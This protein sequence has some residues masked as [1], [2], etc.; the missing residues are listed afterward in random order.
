MDNDEKLMIAE[1]SSTFIADEIYGKKTTSFTS[2]SKF[3]M[4]A[5]LFY[6]CGMMMTTGSMSEV[7]LLLF[8]TQALIPL[9]RKTKRDNSGMGQSKEATKKQSKSEDYKTRVEKMRN[10]S[11]NEANIA[12]TAAG[13]VDRYCTQYL[14]KQAYFYLTLVEIL[15]VNQE[16]AKVIFNDVVEKAR[17]KVDPLDTAMNATVKTLK[18]M[19]VDDKKLKK[20]T[21]QDFR[22]VLDLYF[23][24]SF[25][26][27]Y[28][29]NE[30][31][32]STDMKGIF[33]LVDVDPN[34]VDNTK[35]KIAKIA[36]LKG[37]LEHMWSQREEAKNKEEEKEPEWK[38]TPTQEELRQKQKENAKEKKLTAKK[39][40][41][42]ERAE[43]VRAAAKAAK[44]SGPGRRAA[45]KVAP[46]SAAQ[47]EE[48]RVYQEQLI[49]AVTTVQNVRTWAA[50]VQHVQPQ[51]D[52][53]DTAESTHIVQNVQPQAEYTDTARR[54][55]E[56]IKLKQAAGNWAVSR[57]QKEH[58]DARDILSMQEQNNPDLLP[59]LMP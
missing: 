4:T 55:V 57:V 18:I 53:A 34:M 17:H 9:I 28:F 24:N 1:V 48:E 59:H 3:A 26:M 52:L 27:L 33:K 36:A 44:Q 40:S 43:R 51:A 7:Q 47:K 15:D 23:M 39:K 32:L 19:E 12:K 16:D 31:E 35:A 2:M 13:T 22:E 56:K 6:I 42:A 29:E 5:R 25:W 10:A 37:Y 38:V 58:K 54:T 30:K 46:K 41:A 45:T 21:V 8:R 14:E 20:Y 50:V 11:K 49:D